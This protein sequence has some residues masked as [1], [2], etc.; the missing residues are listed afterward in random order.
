MLGGPASRIFYLKKVWVWLR[1][2][3]LLGRPELSIVIALILINRGAQK[4]PLK[5][6]LSESFL[7][8]GL[9]THHAIDA[10]YDMTEEIFILKYLLT[11]PQ[12][13]EPG[14]AS[15]VVVAP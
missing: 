2:A 8:E 15:V 11:M 12:G 13:C 6:G 14:T 1:P 9:F 5:R 7:T 3:Q 4:K 10:T